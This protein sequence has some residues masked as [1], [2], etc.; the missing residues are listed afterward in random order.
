MTDTEPPEC[1]VDGCEKESAYLLTCG[2]RCRPH[3]VRDQ[4]KTVSW[5]DHVMPASSNKDDHE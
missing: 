2:D 1:G 3:A 4:P 5:L